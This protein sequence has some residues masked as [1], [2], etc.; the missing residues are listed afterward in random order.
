MNIHE[1]QA[2]EILR[3]YGVA[4]PDGVVILDKKDVKSEIAKLD[5]DLYVVKAQIH[6][7]GRGKAGGVKLT[8]NISEA[9]SLASSMFGMNLVTHQTGPGGQDVRRVYVESGSK[10]KKEYY[11]SVVVD[12][13]TGSPVF[14][15]S[16]E[17]GVNIEV[18]A[19]ESPEKII[20]QH[21]NTDDMHPFQARKIGFALGFKGSALKQFAALAMK[22]YKIFIELDADQIEIN[23]LV[24]TE[25]DSVMALDAKIN[26]D[27]NALFKHK[28]ITALR[29]TS[30]EDPLESRS[31]E[32]ELSYVKMDGNIGCMVNG[33]GLA[34]ST[35]DIIKYYGEE[36]ANFLDVG[37]G[38]D[39]ER[40]EE[41]FK[42]IL[43]DSNV[44]AILVNIFGGIMKCD[45]IAAGVIAAVQSIKMD[46]PLVVRLAGTNFEIAKKMLNES[47]L[48]IISA[49]D[50]EDAAK[51]A[52][53][54]VKGL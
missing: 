19:E 26:F 9:E 32:H 46:I 6:A 35:M 21:I 44:K 14:I 39:K 54:A 36:P 52:V 31:K 3:K 29:D 18:I 11:L 47:G 50:L 20:K 40:V 43:S 10:I 15:A 42:I 4:V 17:G 25:D 5:T 33:A 45:I 53:N 24:L 27:D 22:L 7:G 41:A 49:D 13:G 2:K 30:E 12:R 8:K 1:Y 38:A 51:K 16:Q 37:G 48:N 34:M 28:E 23:P